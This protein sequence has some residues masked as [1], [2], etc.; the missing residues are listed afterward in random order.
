[1]TLRGRLLAKRRE[2]LQL[3][4]DKPK[5]DSVV[6]IGSRLRLNGWAVSLDAPIASVEGRKLGTGTRGPITEKV[7]TTFMDAI[8]GRID[9][10]KD[11]LTYVND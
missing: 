4:L 6:V 3:S 9:Q 11:W 5:P 2:P 7:Q 1:M 10:Y 8:R